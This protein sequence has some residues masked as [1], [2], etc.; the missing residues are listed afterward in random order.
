MYAHFFFFFF[1]IF[2]IISFFGAEFEKP[3]IG[4]SGKGLKDFYFII[5]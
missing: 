4:I 1:Y 3:K 5:T 2:D